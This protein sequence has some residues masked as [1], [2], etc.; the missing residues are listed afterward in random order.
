MKQQR[1]RTLI[2]MVLALVL[3]VVCLVSLPA[4]GMA[5]VIGGSSWSAPLPVAEKSETTSELLT[6]EGQTIMLALLEG[7][8]DVEIAIDIPEDVYW[9]VTATVEDEQS[10]LWVSTPYVENSVWTFLALD[11][12]ENTMFYQGGGAQNITVSMTN[13]LPANYVA[14]GEEAPAVDAVSADVKVTLHYITA[15][16]AA[17][18]QPQP[19]EPEGQ[20]AEVVE[21]IEETQ[22]AAPSEETEGT[23]SSEEMPVPEVPSPLHTLSATFHVPL[24]NEYPATRLTGQLLQCPTQYHPMIAIP[25]VNA[26]ADSELKL[27]TGEGFP[28]MTRYTMDGET[29]LLYDSGTIVVPANAAITLDFSMVEEPVVEETPS[30]ELPEEEVVTDEAV[31]AEILAEE[32]TEENVEGTEETNENVQ[33]QSLTLFVGGHEYPLAYAEAPVLDKTQAP[34]IMKG[35]T[36][37]LPMTYQWNTI[38]PT[39]SVE[40]LKSDGAA[41]VWEV[42]DADQW[43]AMDND[44][45]LRLSVVGQTPQAGTYRLTVTWAENEM[46]LYSLQT[47]FYVRS[48]KF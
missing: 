36:F 31:T 32:A 1:M 30:E 25:L 27:L 10:G 22:E 14:E 39:V 29:Y 19:T 38:A 4:P 26:E 12:V 2:N 48:G 35:S 21:T 41:L 13:Q 37:V 7:S 8:R 20:P 24:Q 5:H 6:E 18:L 23:G 28:A 45:Q 17:L 43:K 11:G 3:V 33:E 44:A 9:Y 42:M 47:V 15:A 40:Q 16:E 46:T 34:F